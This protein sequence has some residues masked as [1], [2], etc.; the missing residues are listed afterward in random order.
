MKI[1]TLCLALSLLV[2][3]SACGQNP[4]SNVQKDTE[5][6]EK[7]AEASMAA[8]RAQKHRFEVKTCKLYY[9]EQQVVLDSLHLFEKVMGS[10]H[11][12]EFDYYY[13]E[14]PLSF[15]T[16]RVKFGDPR[17][18]VMDVAIKLSP[19]A[20]VQRD[21]DMNFDIKKRD[22]MNYA[23]PV[24]DGYLLI[25][26]QLVN[27][28]T[29]IEDFNKKRAEE[30]LRPFTTFLSIRNPGVIYG[31]RSCIPAYNA[32]ATTEVTLF[33]NDENAF[34]PNHRTTTVWELRYSYE[35]SLR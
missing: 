18:I 29:K 20:E 12:G 6:T 33:Y 7:S 28:D 16:K 23:R 22:S 32:I 30:D 27:A 8:Y 1:T 5:P 19:N 13:R 10:D 21:L 3:T 25:D 17:E 11:I 24:L 4:K 15:R 9:N 35:Q 34:E 31:L 14:K 2:I 26:G